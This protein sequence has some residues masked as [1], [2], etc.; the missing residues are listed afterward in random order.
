MKTRFAS[1]VL[2]AGVVLGLTACGSK[3][4]VISVGSKN[5][6]EQMI[7]GEI[8]AAHLDKQLPGVKIV[9]KL[10]LGGTMVVHG[11]LESGAIDLFVEDTGTAL[12]MI[13]KEDVPRDESVALERARAQYQRLYQLTILTPLGFHHRFVL[14]GQANSPAGIKADT[15]TAAG[16]SG[17]AWKLGLAYDLYDR[18]DTF[19]VLTTKYRLSL[20]D[21]P[22]QM[23]PAAMYE[24]LRSGSLEMAGGYSTDSW[25]DQPDFRMF[26]DDQDLFSSQPACVIVRSQTLK[27]Q[28]G[29]ESALAAL[30]GKFTDD[31][32]RKLNQE[33]D[34]KH[35]KPEEIAKAFLASAGL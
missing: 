16:A 17:H 15:L 34:L 2:L 26:K 19:T 25:I 23:E 3:Q 20:P 21:M 10:G 18:K 28:A 7:L 30:S 24:A 32:M 22:K 13:L 29:L 27:A 5:T 4:P 1:A 12:G 6:T 35:R 9:R 11:A 33:G 31:S 8:L 14:V